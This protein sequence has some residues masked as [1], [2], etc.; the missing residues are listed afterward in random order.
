MDQHD[1]ERTHADIREL[2]WLKAA[3]DWEVRVGVRTVFWGVTESQHLVDIINQTDA[4]EN[5]DGED[6]LGQPMINYAFIRDWGTV[7]LY[8]LTGFRER[9]YTSSAGRQW[10]L[11]YPLEL[12]QTQ[13]RYESSKE[14]KRA[15]FALRWSH[16]VDV[17]DIGVSHFSGTSREPVLEPKSND[18]PTVL[19]PRYDLIEQ[20]GLD[21][22]ATLE[23]WLL[24]LEIISR[25]TPVGP[26]TA[27]T[28]GVENT[29]V[30]IMDSQVDLGLLS[31]YLFDDR[32]PSSDQTSI[33]F[34]NDLVLG[35]RFNFNDVQSSDL[36][37]L[38]ML[39]LDNHSRMFVVEGS[40]RVGDSW[41]LSIEAKIFSAFEA[42]DT[43]YPLRQDD[44][45][46][47]ELAWYF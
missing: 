39:D 36:L 37:V 33:P 6:K 11:P 25:D 13:A 15:D 41:K 8:L 5:L 22:Q 10:P 42:K 27:M 2:F 40:R 1:S 17:W 3:A 38:V 24:K 23:D 4:A 29:L 20:S 44:H 47:A 9:N 35:T 46:Q 26:Y 45:L 30:G 31:E 7:D 28:A 16:T 34:A 21:L 43:L 32:N 12:D 14:D 18:E 19:V